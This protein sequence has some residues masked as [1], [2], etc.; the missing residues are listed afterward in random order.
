MSDRTQLTILNSMAGQDFEQALD[1]HIAWGLK[2]LDLKDAIYDKT[3]DQLSPQE[4]E[5]ATRE[6]ER[7]NLTV[8]T[9]S[10]GIFYDDLEQG[11]D[12]FRARFEPALDRILQ[13]A[14]IFQPKNVRLLSAKSSKRESFDNCTDYLND[15]HPWLIP[16][17]RD[18]IERLSTAGFHV[19]IE[20]EVRGAIF[21][22]PQEILDFFEALDCGNKA[23]LTWD[24]SNLWEE[25]T[26]PSLNVYEQLK[27]LIGLVHVKGG[28][29]DSESGGH[30]WA[31]RLEDATWPVVEIVR[32]AVRDGVSPVVCINPSHGKRN[33]GYN[34][35]LADYESDILFLRQHI[36][37][38]E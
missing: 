29:E 32:T 17:Y 6:I 13:T 11:E 34:G 28:R 22:H 2:V 5:Q 16:M 14:P 38:I 1:Q 19:V 20:N 30:R 26:F 23:L 31:S 9:L 21:S 15:Q 36:E 10:T 25:G 7:R 4:A 12:A 8:H 33:P 35:T 37:E 3:V 18:A 24:I 27:P